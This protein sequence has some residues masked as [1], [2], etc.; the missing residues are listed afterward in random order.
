VFKSSEKN[1]GENDISRQ[2]HQ[3]FTRTVFVQ[4]FGARKF[5]TQNTAL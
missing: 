1:V 2:F 4:N 5:Q 3:Q